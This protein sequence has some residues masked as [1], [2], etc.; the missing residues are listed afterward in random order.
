[1]ICRVLLV[2]FVIAYVLAIFLHLTNSYGW[3]GQQPDALS[4]IFLIPLGLPWNLIDLPERALPA[5]GMGAPLINLLLI[6]ILCR[7]QKSR[8]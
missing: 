4:G 1:M 2:G 6:F 8:Q 3:F 5:L 7:T